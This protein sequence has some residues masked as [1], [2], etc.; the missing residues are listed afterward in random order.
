MSLTYKLT[1]F[2]RK[3]IAEAPR[4]RLKAWDCGKPACSKTYVV[5][6]AKITPHAFW[7]KS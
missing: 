1:K 6:P 4:P 5:D 2:A 3:W 7:T